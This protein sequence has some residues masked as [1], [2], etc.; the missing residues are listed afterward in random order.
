MLPYIASRVRKTK[1][2]KPMGP[3]PKSPALCQLFAKIDGDPDWHPGKFD[4]SDMG[5]CRVLQGPKLNAVVRAAY[6]IRDEVGDVT[7]PLVAAACPKALLNPATGQMVDKARV[8]TVF[9][10]ACK[11]EGAD[12]AWVNMY[13]AAK[14]QLTDKHIALR[15]AFG[16]YMRGLGHTPEFYYDRL[17]WTDL[18]NSIQPLSVKRTQEQAQARKGGK[19]W[20]SKS[21]RTKNTNLKRSRTPLRQATWE[22]VRLWWAPILVKGKLHI[23]FLGGKG[24]PGETEA[25]AAQ[26][27]HAVKAGLMKRFPTS[28]AP[29]IV[30]VDRGKGFF[31]ISSGRITH[32]FKSALRECGLRAYWGDDASR[33]PGALQE[34]ML[35]ETAV[36]WI[37]FH[38]RRTLPKRPWEETTEQ[39]VSRSKPIA[40]TINKEYDVEGLCRALPKRIDALVERRG[41]R[42]P[43]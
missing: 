19:G 33:Q 3:H 31:D 30:F 32:G 20:F 12:D 43:W 40:A 25:G 2:G 6:R 8:Y 27:V 18:C 36:R 29:S 21:K 26:L 16:E 15:R 22:T 23:E 35:H 41:E 9:R 14:E 24:F 5:R 1:H 38:E 34:I 28:E 11:D 42:V 4:S 13:R 7:F 10:E 37:R 17:V 39:F